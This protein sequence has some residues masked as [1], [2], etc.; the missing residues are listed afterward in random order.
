[1][2]NFQKC[3]PVSTV[4]YEG[5]YNSE[6]SSDDEDTN[7]EYD[8]EARTKNIETIEG[9]IGSLATSF[10]AVEEHDTEFIIETAH[11]HVHQSRSMRGLVQL[12]TQLTIQSL[13][14]QKRHP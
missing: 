13:L 5:L 4:T 2:Y 9:N 8:I 6:S 1:M 12:K 11:H 3:L 7:K 10:L 14:H